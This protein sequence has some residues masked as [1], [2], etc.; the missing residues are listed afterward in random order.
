MGGTTY[1]IITAAIR[2]KHVIHVHINYYKA[3]VFLGMYTCNNHFVRTRPQ[4]R[5]SEVTGGG[6]SV[7]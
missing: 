3:S 7:V 4:E 2:L 5:G 6:M 1:E